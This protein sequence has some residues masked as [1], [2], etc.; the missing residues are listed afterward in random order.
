[1][2]FL[3]R[4]GLE[5][6]PRSRYVYLSW[7]LWEKKEGQLDDARRLFERGCKLNPNDTALS[8]VPSTPQDCLLG[9]RLHAESAQSPS[10]FWFL[11]AFLASEPPVHLQRQPLL[12]ST[13]RHKGVAANLGGVPRAGVGNVGGGA[14]QHRPRA[15]PAADCV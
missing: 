3:L 12:L 15:E 1:M 7:A 8:Q 10:L 11:W 6:N 14:R 9:C 2:R 4:K 5:A 13:V